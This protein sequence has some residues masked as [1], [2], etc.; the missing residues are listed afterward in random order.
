MFASSSEGKLLAFGHVLPPRKLATKFLDRN[1]TE[2]RDEHAA[3]I[4]TA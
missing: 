2:L 1:F 4:A 3:Q